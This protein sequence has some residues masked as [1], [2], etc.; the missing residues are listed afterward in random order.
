MSIVDC[1]DSGRMVV[2]ALPPSLDSPL[3]S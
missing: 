2:D 3:S 1:S